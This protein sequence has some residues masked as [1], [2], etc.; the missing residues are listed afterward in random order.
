VAYSATGRSDDAELFV[1]PITHKE[2]IMSNSALAPEVE[3]LK[4]R[5]K[6]TWMAGDYDRFSRYME[7]GA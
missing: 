5:L 6:R 1:D 7:S 2:D 3:N 4:T